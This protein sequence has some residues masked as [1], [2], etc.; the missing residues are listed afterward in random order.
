[1]KLLII[2]SEC[3]LSGDGIKKYEDE[4]NRMIREDGY[5]ILPYGFKTEVV[6]VDCLDV[7]TPKLI[8]I[9]PNEVE[10]KCNTSSCAWNVKDKCLFNFN[11]CADRDRKEKK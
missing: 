2:K 11:N 7:F 9:E 10:V 4:F 8:T 5:L 6:E 1:M 3:R